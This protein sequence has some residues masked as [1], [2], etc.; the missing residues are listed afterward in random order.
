MNKR[1]EGMHA[2]TPDFV[3][4]DAAAAIALYEKAFGAE[5]GMKM[6]VPGS[7]MIM[8]A[9]IMIGDS[10]LFIS[11]VAPGIEREAP[12]AGSLSSVAFYHYVDDV[13]VAYKRAVGAGMAGKNEPSDMFWGDRTAVVND[14]F[15]GNWTL[16][17]HVK[18]VSA[19]EID[20]AMAAFQNQAT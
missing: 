13:D 1:P 16:A 5:L 9:E 19:E 4:R 18:D 7:E 14:G 20:A 15:G 2:I 11:D 8:H 12:K 3:V 10:M 6:M 17:C